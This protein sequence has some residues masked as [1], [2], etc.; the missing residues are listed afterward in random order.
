MGVCS[1]TTAEHWQYLIDL[2]T[3]L[4]Y[5]GE[6]VPRNGALVPDKCQAS[7]DTIV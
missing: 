6:L 7:I 4:K 3:L 5:Y 1:A 2:W